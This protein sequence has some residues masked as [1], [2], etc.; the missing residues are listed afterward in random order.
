[1]A[2]AHAPQLLAQQRGSLQALA[3]A[4]L[5]MHLDKA[6][7]R[8]SWG[9]Q[10]LSDAQVSAGGPLRLCLA[11]APLRRLALLCCV[12]SASGLAPAA[13]P[14]VLASAQRTV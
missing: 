4:A 3:A 2:H 14:S 10:E 12:G 7:Q 6:L 13:M 5:G 11:P 1:V 8:S 9:L